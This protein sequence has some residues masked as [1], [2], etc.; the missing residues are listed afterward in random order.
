VTA[1][2]NALD[3]LAIAA[4]RD[5]VEQTCGG[6]LLKMAQ[7]GYRTGILDL[8]R[9]EMGTRGTAEERTREAAEAAKILRVSW[10]EALDIPDGRVENTWE[11]RLKI[12]RVIREQRPRVVILPYWEGRHPD[13]YTTSKLGYEACFLAGLAKLDVEQALSIQHSAFSQGKTS[14]VGVTVGSSVSTRVSATMGTG[15][16]AISTGV[17]GTVEGHGF[18]RAERTPETAALAAEELPAHRP[19][20]IIYA[21]LYYDIRPTFVV[22]ISEQFETRFQSLIAYK[23]Q[24]TDQEAGKDFFP[25]QADIHARTEA[26]ARFYGMMGGVAYAEPFLQKEV[27]LLEDLLQIPVKSI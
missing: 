22:D 25:A 9:G 13:H 6:T 8:T 10:R 1:I 7:R 24:F 2:A 4:H 18:S 20:K 3:I 5:D 15:V 16:S 12:A 17:D 14:D 26:M 19:F 11:N 27:G 21:T 23:S